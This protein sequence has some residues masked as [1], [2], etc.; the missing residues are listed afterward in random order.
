MIEVKNLNKIY[1]RRR[2]N[3]NHVLR[4][5][6]LTLPDTGFVCILGPSGCGKTSLLN[7]IGGLDTYESG[8]ILTGTATNGGAVQLRAERKQNFGYI[9]QNYYLLPEHSVGY[10]VY[11]G[12]H[13]LKL[14]HKEKLKRVKEALQAVEME[15]YLRRNV[16]ELSGGQQQR[17]AIARALAR[18]PKVILADEPTGNLDEENTRNICSLLRSISK[19]SLV[20]MVTHEQRI[21]RFFA[22][23]IITLDGGVIRTDE[24]QW[25]RGALLEEG[26]R[27]LYTNEF[28]QAELHENTVNLRLF[29]EA[30]AAPAEISV[31][32]L[33]DRIVIKLDDSRAVTCGKPQDPP[34]LADGARPVLTLEDVERMSIPWA[35]E[36]TAYAGA[37]KGLRWRDLLREALHMNRG[38][39]LRNIGT[40]IF[41]VVLTALA[42]MTI[43]DYLKVSSIDPEDFIQTHSQ[44]LDITLERGPKA[45]NT[46]IGL[47]TLSNEFKS[48]LA[49]FDQEYTYVPHIAT[50]A[51][52][53][54]NPFLQ[55]G[56]L[57]VKLSHFSYVPLEMLDASTL[58]MG[59]MPESPDEV[60]VD[61]W[62]LEKVMEIDSVAGN[63]IN[64]VD[65]FLGKQINY[66]RQT[67][68]PTIVGICDS[69]EPGI[70]MM[71]DTFASLGAA[72]TYVA[73][74]SSLQARFP[75]Q[76][77]DVVLN[78]GECIVLPNNAGSTFRDKLYAN[79]NTNSKMNFLIVKSI[80]ET[81]FYAWIVIP[82][83]DMDDLM[84]AMSFQRFWIFCEDKAAMKDF[85]R[86]IEESMEGR[87][88]LTIRDSYSTKM[89]DY[90]EAT[91]LRANARTI[92]TVTIILLSLVMLYLLR[93]SQVYEKIGMLAVY[94]LLGIPA[95]KTGMIFTIESLLTTL[96]TALPAAAAM[97]AGVTLL[98]DKV[99]MLLPWQA[100]AWVYA[101]VTVYHLIVTMIPMAGLLRLP[102]A[103]LASKF[104]F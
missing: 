21:A 73:S 38:G 17:V 43:G 72:G 89:A 104:D 44:V 80:E 18:K 41:L 90:E 103:R 35:P 54:G 68:S 16:G 88:T 87:I 57:S 52:V 46:T 28:E 82:D 31:V 49:E 19:K 86:E 34:V 66:N 78:P 45:E 60:V 30:G 1:D 51:E 84:L 56:E 32:V 47:L 81:D 85:L 36:E 64:G 42:A 53:R 97:Y 37:G 94:R 100:A 27:V 7:A 40:R 15:R 10:N 48:H 101:G 70:Y 50:S 75:G 20:L 2:Q 63:G 95:G 25:E 79:Y 67:L 6:S 61:R 3:E 29:R 65:Y 76:Y 99:E 93:R 74:L 58:I 33:K 12:L 23:R 102:P 96:T 91:R 83:S 22:D 59:R 13:S 69:G 26:G 24:S 39:G 98:G 9:F 92:V 5:V 62:I 14:S 71:P 55:A 8:E 4:D 11:L 77:D